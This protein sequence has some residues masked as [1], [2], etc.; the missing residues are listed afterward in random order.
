VPHHHDRGAR[1]IERDLKIIK[2]IE[3]NNE[4]A[5]AFKADKV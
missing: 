2:K 3:L 5:L 1:C 4:S